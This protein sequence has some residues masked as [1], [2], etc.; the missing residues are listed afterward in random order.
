MQM[1]SLVLPDV[2]LSMFDILDL[3]IA[4]ARMSGKGSLIS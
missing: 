4:L 1:Q 3:D 2:H